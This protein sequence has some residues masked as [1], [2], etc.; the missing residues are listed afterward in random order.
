MGDTQMNECH[1]SYM[2]QLSRK[3]IPIVND[4]VN[5]LTSIDWAAPHLGPIS[6]YLLEKKKLDNFAFKD[7]AG[8]AISKIKR[9]ALYWVSLRSK[10]K[11]K[12]WIKA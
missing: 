12:I 9:H 10:D 8:K 2:I 1:P 3:F 11:N 4:S 7:I 6:E 5:H